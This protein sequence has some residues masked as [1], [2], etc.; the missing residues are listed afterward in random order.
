[1]NQFKTIDDILHRGI[2]PQRCYAWDQRNES[3]TSFEATQHCSENTSNSQSTALG[4]LDF[5]VSSQRQAE[6]MATLKG[7]S[8][9][10][11]TLEECNRKLLIALETST[12]TAISISSKVDQIIK[13]S[14]HQNF[15]ISEPCT[16]SKITGTFLDEGELDAM[17]VADYLQARGRCNANNTFEECE[18]EREISFDQ[19]LAK[20]RR[21]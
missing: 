10:I 5:L 8:D 18:L 4:Q 19:Q 12:Q 7:L 16:T 14:N 3:S 9:R 20:R 17:S 6:I 2:H 1:M 15:D 21:A 11:T 13:T